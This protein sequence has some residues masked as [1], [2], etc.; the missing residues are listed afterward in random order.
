[1]DSLEREIY[2]GD[3]DSSPQMVK[4]H[5][6]PSNLSRDSGL[7][8]SDT[9]LYDDGNE[10][11][12][13]SERKLSHSRSSDKSGR[14]EHVKL[15]RSYTSG[16]VVPPV[17]PPRRNRRRSDDPPMFDSM[18]RRYPQSLLPPPLLENN[19][20]STS[21]TPNMTNEMLKHMRDQYYAKNISSD[22]LG[23]GE[24]NSE[25]DCVDDFDEILKRFDIGT[26]RKSESGA[27]LYYNEQL[28]HTRD[29]D[30][31]H[32]PAIRQQS[33]DSA[34]VVSPPLTPNTATSISSVDSD[35]MRFRCPK[36]RAPTP[37]EEIMQSEHVSSEQR[38]KPWMAR[39]SDINALL[40][41]GNHSTPPSMTS[42]NL[43][44]DGNYG[45]PAAY[46]LVRSASSPLKEGTPK[47]MITPPTSPAHSSGNSVTPMPATNT[48]NSLYRRQHFSHSPRGS[49]SSK[50]SSM[51]SD[52]SSPRNSAGMDIQVPS[53]ADEEVPPPRPPKPAAFMSPTA[54]ESLPS[55]HTLVSS[56]PPR[57]LL[58]QQFSKSGARLARVA[59]TP[60]GDDYF[61]GRGKLIQGAV[62][63][64]NLNRSP[65]AAQPSYNNNKEN[66]TR[67]DSYRHEKPVGL[68]R[69]KQYSLEKSASD[70]RLGKHFPT[71]D[72]SAVVVMRRQK[73]NESAYCTLDRKRP[74][75]P[76][77]YH[78]AMQRKEL[79]RRDAVDE[80]NFI[81]DQDRITQTVNSARARQ[82]YE[83]SMKKYAKEQGVPLKDVVHPTTKLQDRAELAK[84]RR[85]ADHKFDQSLK[86]QTDSS[87]NTPRPA[88]LQRSHSDSHEHLNKISRAREMHS[89]EN[90]METKNGKQGAAVERLRVEHAVNLERSSSD[91]SHLKSTKDKYRQQR[92]PEQSQVFYQPEETPKR[93]CTP[94]RESTKQEHCK[95][96]A[97]PV[98]ITDQISAVRETTGTTSSQ[99][100]IHWSVA[101]LRNLY[102][103]SGKKGPSNP[104]PFYSPEN[105][106]PS[107]VKSAHPQEGVSPSGYRVPSSR[108]SPERVAGK[109]HYQEPINGLRASPE[110]RSKTAASSRFEQAQFAEESY[111]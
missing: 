88:N 101:Q 105:E 73:S 34:V 75:R 32:S 43:R 12:G 16:S 78:E 100:N 60:K 44:V 17:P 46:A 13:N 81:T 30:D 87:Q 39:G 58:K 53:L 48:P 66:I 2:T 47:F 102:K 15:S 69:L 95:R 28:I 99:K 77:T 89:I 106:P 41:N 49:L 62:K 22:S 21:M 108:R 65:K 11:E 23:S 5:L 54:E 9:Q 25:T 29:D 80:E 55:D 93:N 110:R 6:S 74:A 24:E 67:S 36:P 14:Y 31:M 84:L 3:M 38:Q 90:S 61:P 1:M 26:I 7:T 68:E 91:S 107:V 59:M 18:Q 104:A 97:P 86:L 83:D 52:Y 33:N 51:D 64:A 111:V 37:D 103:E 19:G 57:V 56:P 27:K 71:K 94:E 35:T 98:D 8:L 50:G 109:T 10:K 42:V 4:S 63:N 82:L 70:S 45:H 72:D 96:G 79:I 92:R 85:I 40:D 20:R 76:P